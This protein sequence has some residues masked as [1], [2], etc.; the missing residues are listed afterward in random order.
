MVKV[1]AS[2]IL[3]E[4]KQIKIFVEKNKSLPRTCT[5]NDGQTVDIY[6]MSFMMA[7]LLLNQRV[8]MWTFNENIRKYDVDRFKDKLN[9]V[10]VGNSRYMDM[11]SRFVAYSKKNGRVPSNIMVSGEYGSASFELFTYCLAKILTFYHKN[12]TLPS[13]CIFNKADVQGNK[14][15]V[16][17]SKK[18]TVTSTSKA[19]KKIKKDNCENPYTSS[20]H[21]TTTGCNRLGQCTPYWCGPHSIHQAIKKFNITKYN[22]KTLAGWC[23]TTKSGTD[24]NGINTCIAKVSKQTGKKLKVQWRNYSDMGK[25]DIER[26]KNIGKLLCKPNVSII[27]HISYIN[28]GK[29]TIGK[30]FGHY[31]CIDK[32]NISTEYVRAMNSLGD[33]N[34]DGSYKGRLQDRPF[35]VQSYFARNTSGGQPALCIITYEK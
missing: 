31:E 21:Y 5:L 20:P 17:N 3:Q 13:Y 27:W 19:P 32:I 26:F 10:K 33:K 30:K 29:S 11:V 7:N 6:N 35:N 14:K 34:T 15:T 23:G 9:N 8:E 18:S 4:A 25:T 16:Q 2:S 12:N 28:G 1:K 24:H 22:E